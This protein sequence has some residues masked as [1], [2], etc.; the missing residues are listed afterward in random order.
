MNPHSS[1]SG[2]GRLLAEAP[3]R[4]DLNVSLLFIPDRTESESP[5]S[6]PLLISV[7]LIWSLGLEGD[8][9]ESI[10]IPF[11]PRTAEEADAGE[12]CLERGWT[13]SKSSPSAFTVSSA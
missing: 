2:N 7:P 11:E 5:P 12:R 13:N 1:V 4:S 3:E 6:V 9:Y 10:E 8:G